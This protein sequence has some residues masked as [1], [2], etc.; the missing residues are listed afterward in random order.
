M[1][2][3]NQTAPR[4]DDRSHSGSARIFKARYERYLTLARK[5]ISDNDPI[6]AENWHQHAEHFFR[7]LKAS[8]A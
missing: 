3:P 6:A 7:M 2:K 1:Y 5:A 8:S 4:L